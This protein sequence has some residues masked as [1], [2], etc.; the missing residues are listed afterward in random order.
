MLLWIHGV[1]LLFLGSTIASVHSIRKERKESATLGFWLLVSGLALLFPL[2]LLRYREQVMHRGAFGPFEALISLSLF[3]GIL[4]LL[5]V[6]VLRIRQFPA[7]S[8]PLA[9]AFAIASAFFQRRVPRPDPILESAFPYAHVFFALLAYTSLLMASLAAAIYLLQDRNL[10]RH[11]ASA[12]RLPSL[13][14]L[15]RTQFAFLILGQVFLTLL[16]VTGLVRKV[17]EYG[18]ILRIDAMV[19]F[20]IVT[21]IIYGLLVTGRAFSRIR[22][23]KLAILSLFFLLLVLITA[24]SQHVFPGWHAF[25]AGSPPLVAGTNDTY[26]PSISQ[27]VAGTQE[28]AG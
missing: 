26:F 22:G 10:K 2:V 3:T 6:L 14:D 15:D 24:A 7:F 25:L 1:F 20:S 21:W 16:I 23:K 5:P 19:L 9:A 8:S 13:A 17:Q 4:S 28:R 18:Q 12:Q 11:I 27:R